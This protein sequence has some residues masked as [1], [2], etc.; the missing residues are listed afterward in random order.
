MMFV[1]IEATVD[2]NRGHIAYVNREHVVEATLDFERSSLALEPGGK[3]VIH[4]INGNRVT[5]KYDDAQKAIN[6]LTLLTTGREAE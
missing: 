5:Y 1:R 2:D 3:L 4:F 6:A